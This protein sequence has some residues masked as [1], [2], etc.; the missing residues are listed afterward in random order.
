MDGRITFG[1]QPAMG[2]SDVRDG[3]AVISWARA[4]GGDAHAAL[5][6]AIATDFAFR[7]EQ[8]Q[9]FIRAGRANMKELLQ[10]GLKPRRP[11]HRRLS[12]HR[13]AFGFHA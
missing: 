12:R 1:V 8:P 6:T 13:N 7:E 2:E 4:V 10:V 3:W 9:W 11:H 5:A